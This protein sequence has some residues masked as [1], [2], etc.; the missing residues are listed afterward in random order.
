M[1][2][3]AP[4]GRTR[5]GLLQGPELTTWSLGFDV[6]AKPFDDPRVRRAVSLSLDRARLAAAFAGS[7]APATALVPGGVPGARP[8]ACAACTRDP[9]QAKTLAAAGAPFTLVVPDDPVDRRVAARVVAL[10]ASAVL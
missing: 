9:D 8:A 3:R 6:R 4:D 2:G 5:S 7:W 10:L 1:Y